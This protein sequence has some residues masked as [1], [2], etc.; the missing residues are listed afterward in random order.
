VAWEGL[1]RDFSANPE[2]GR[3]NQLSISLETAHPAKFPF[4]IREILNIS[5]PLPVSLVDI[6][7]QTEEYV[8]LKNN[9]E[10]MRDFLQKNYTPD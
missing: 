6:K 5:P 1:H 8:S 3:T 9:Y 10:N 4:Q 2:D 7:S